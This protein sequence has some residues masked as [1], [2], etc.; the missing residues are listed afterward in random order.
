MGKWCAA[1]LVLD[2]GE[3]VSG[4]ALVA[5][6]DKLQAKLDGMPPPPMAP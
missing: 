5:A 6:L 2:S 3:E 4:L 1:T